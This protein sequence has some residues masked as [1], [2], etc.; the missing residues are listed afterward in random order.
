MV[1]IVY[2]K[3]LDIE[4]PIVHYAMIDRD[5]RS[6]KE[7]ICDEDDT[8]ED[9]VKR[10][11]AFFMIEDVDKWLDFSYKD[12]LYSDYKFDHDWICQSHKFDLIPSEKKSEYEFYHRCKYRNFNLF[13]MQYWAYQMTLYHYRG[14]LLHSKKDE[15]ENNFDM[16]YYTGNEDLT[17]GL[18]NRPIKLTSEPMGVPINVGKM[19]EDNMGTP[20]RLF[21]LS[22]TEFETLEE[23]PSYYI[24]L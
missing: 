22:E 7:C 14:N 18:L 21:R 23:I 5:M 3:P 10:I 8:I 17:Y 2:R 11:L 4:L 15:V 24:E 9:N 19:T 16:L 20:I 1:E 6:N 13:M 12:F